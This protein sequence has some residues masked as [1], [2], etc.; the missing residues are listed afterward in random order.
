MFIMNKDQ[1]MRMAR[2]PEFIEGIYNYCDRWCERC[3]YTSQCLLY[4][5]EEEADVGDQ[6]ELQ[7]DAFWNSLRESLQLA[8]QLL[9]EHAE[10]Q[11]IDL[12][13]MPE[14]PVDVKA[15]IEDAQKHPIVELARDY[16][17]QV[18]LWF[19]VARSELDSHNQLL[20]QQSQ[21][22][23]NEDAAMEEAEELTDLLDV[24]QWYRHQIAVKLTR[25]LMSKQDLARGELPGDD[26][27][28]NDA[29]GSAK[30]ALIGINRSMAAWGQL[31]DAFP[32]LE[33]ET[34]PLLVKL[35]KTKKL[36]LQIFPDVHDFVRPGF[37]E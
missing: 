37:D 33:D 29:N 1:L 34:L 18:G 35:E 28:Q 11:G 36:L 4:A 30:V 25:A 7:N 3:P 20:E 2:N 5:M 12:K 8:K 31:Y 19:E 24:V 15:D 10:K 13:P 26:P 9:E 21:M 23:R 27:V 16:M 6:D 32:A 22:G 14:E 17:D